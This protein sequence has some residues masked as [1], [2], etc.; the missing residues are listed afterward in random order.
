M[1]KKATRNWEDVKFPLNKSV[2][3]DWK[4]ES[5]LKHTKGE[6][7]LVLE[8]GTEELFLKDLTSYIEI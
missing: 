8:N 4:E 2:L 1:L 7:Y 6:G 5:V 3:Q